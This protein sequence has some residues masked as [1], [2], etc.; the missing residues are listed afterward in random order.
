MIITQ[1]YT[2][3]KYPLKN[4]KTAAHIYSDAS[5][6]E[7]A[8][9]LQEIPDTVGTHA[10]FNKPSCNQLF[11]AEIQSWRITQNGHL[12]GM[13]IDQRMVETTPVLAGDTC[14]TVAQENKYFRY[15]FQHHIANKLKSKDPDT[16]AA[17]A[18]LMQKNYSC[19]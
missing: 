11:L 5:P 4:L 6:K 15:F 10:V 12:Q 2:Y 18:T 14:L 8:E 1:L 17:V 19:F 13:I 16:L 7:L 3:P 9:V